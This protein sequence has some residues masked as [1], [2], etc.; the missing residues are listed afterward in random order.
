MTRILKDNMILLVMTLFCALFFM[1]SAKL[2]AQTS[3]QAQTSLQAQSPES[4]SLLTE[5]EEKSRALRALNCDFT[6]IKK[7][8][9]FDEP[10]VSKGRLSFQRPHSLR[11]EYLSPVESGFVLSGNKG[12]TWSKA[13]GLLRHED[14]SRNPGLKGMSTQIVAWLSFDKEFLRANYD[15]EVLAANPAKLRLRPKS[16]A[17]ATYIAS[18]YVEFAPGNEHLVKLVL[19]ESGDDSTTLEF[20]NVHINPVLKADLFTIP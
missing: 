3:F 4:E 20:S 9:L 12:G 1:N 7:L 5:L 11:W 17:L 15:V 16:S 14:L 13:A 19:E 10:V 18:M 2:Q 6:Q 8:A